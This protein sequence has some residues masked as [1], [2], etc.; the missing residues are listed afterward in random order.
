MWYPGSRWTSFPP[1][2]A[3]GS[4]WKACSH[5]QLMPQAY[6]VVFLIRPHNFYHSRVLDTRIHMFIDQQ[7][8]LRRHMYT[9]KYCSLKQNKK[10]WYW[11]LSVQCPNSVNHVSS[12]CMLFS[13]GVTDGQKTSDKLELHQDGGFV[14]TPMSTHGQSFCWGAILH[15]LT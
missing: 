9:C 6:I 12:L 13:S 4:K 1:A 15:V 10:C 5:V 14:C 8:W 7:Q 3:Q 11:A 2:Q